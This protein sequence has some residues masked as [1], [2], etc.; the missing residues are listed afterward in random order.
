MAQHNA[1]TTQYVKKGVMTLLCKNMDFMLSQLR[2]I[3]EWNENTFLQ[4][5][6][7]WSACTIIAHGEHIL[8]HYRKKHEYRCQWSKCGSNQLN[9]IIREMYNIAHMIMSLPFKSRFM[10]RSQGGVLFCNAV[11]HG[12]LPHGSISSYD[13]FLPGQTHRCLKS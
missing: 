11:C 13:G 2:F 9:I 7:L 3:H 1:A 5:I 8:T 10:C 6:I 4:V 12:C